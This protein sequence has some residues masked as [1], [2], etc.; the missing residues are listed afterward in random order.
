M[1][2]VQRLHTARALALLGLLGL[3]LVACRS[4]PDPDPVYKPTESVLE[5]VTVLRRHVP[6]DTYR[7][8]PGQDFTGRNVYR[9]SL[10]R[11][12]GIEAI[13]TDALRA[14]HMD[15]VI[16]F[17][18]GRALERL[19]AYE[20]AAKQYRL[21]ADLDSELAVEAFRSA[22]LCDALD[23]VT[24]IAV[25]LN[26]LAEQEGLET[27]ADGM[28][29]LFE[30]RNGRLEVLELQAE[31]SHHVY[32]VQEELERSDTARAEYFLALRQILQDGDV[33]AAAELERLV[34]RHG[35]SK[36]ANR[37]ILAL[38]GLYEDLAMEYVDAHP[39]ESLFFDPVRFQ[40]LV[41][42]TSRLYEVVAN[43]DGRPEKLEAS[44]KLEAF[45]AFALRVDHDRFTQ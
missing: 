42:A 33:R 16:A 21:A 4:T 41:D 3:G 29:E 34:A 23:A 35:G 28:L 1:S 22:D 39:P 2:G 32:V 15:G 38:A 26:E 9:S 44:R 14:S 10:L 30:R 36:N 45:L 20:L 6:D 12:E 31:G 18:K 43:Q 8:P 40:E 7:F 19:Q 24:D 25:G 13:H 5:V 11:L 37:H 17:A 27:D